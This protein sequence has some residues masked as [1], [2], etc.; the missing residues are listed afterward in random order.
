MT[1]QQYI[2]M[3]VITV[4]IIC[5][6]IL[7]TSV[8]GG[9]KKP[10]DSAYKEQIR[11]L[12]KSLD[13]LSRAQ[14][15]NQTLHEQ[16]VAEKDKAILTADSLLNVVIANQSKYQNLNKRYETVATNIRNI[17]GDD[18]AILRAFADY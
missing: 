9:S 5:V 14:L 13:L 12:D 3:G 15:Q 17:S 8:F 16:I 11:L 18:A 1:K 10:D 7:I 2:W 6:M 4:F